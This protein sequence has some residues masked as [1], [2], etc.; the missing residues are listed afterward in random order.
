M[1]LK[2]STPCANLISALDLGRS[3]DSVADIT[4]GYFLDDGGVGVRVPIGLR[5]FSSQRRPDRIKG[6]S[7]LLSNGSWGLF[8]PGVKRQGREA[9]H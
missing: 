2:E 1:Q 9:D 8:P 7:N 3:R 4:T 6:P 5:I